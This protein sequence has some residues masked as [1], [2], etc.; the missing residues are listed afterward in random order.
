MTELEHPGEGGKYV[1]FLSVEYVALRGAMKE[2]GIQFIL[3]LFCELTLNMNVRMAYI[4]LNRR[5]S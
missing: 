3:S 2:Y 5:N 1:K 4:D